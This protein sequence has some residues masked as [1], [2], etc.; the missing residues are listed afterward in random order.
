MRSLT[1]KFNYFFWHHADSP[2]HTRPDPKFI[3]EH[4]VHFEFSVGLARSCTKSLKK[5]GWRHMPLNFKNLIMRND[6]QY[7]IYSGQII[8]FWKKK[9]GSNFVPGTKSNVLAARK[10]N[11][12]ARFFLTFFFCVESKINIQSRQI[13]AHHFPVLY[14]FMKFMGRTGGICHIL[15]RPA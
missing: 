4:L 9:N 6:A 8:G 13:N 3:D 1:H 10:K 5:L 12:F 2:T 15:K 11:E 14:I 7:L